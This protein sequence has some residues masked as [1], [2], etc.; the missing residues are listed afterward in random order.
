MLVYIYGGGFQFGDGSESRYSGEAMAQKEIVVVTFNY[1]LGVFG[2]L[3]LPELTQE[4][5][6]HAS[7]DYGLLD[8]VAALQWVQRNIAAFG[9]DPQ[10]VTIGANPRDRCR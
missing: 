8:Q 10:R 3:A 7:G 9:G 6:N 4:S 1:R 2:Y 5:P